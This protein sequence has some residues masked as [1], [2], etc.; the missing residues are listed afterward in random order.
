MCD[1]L[2]LGNAGTINFV[3]DKDKNQEIYNKSVDNYAHALEFVPDCHKNKKQCVIKLSI[4]PFCNKTCFERCKAKEM[5]DKAVETCSF[6]FDS[7]PD[8]YKIHEMCDKA[9]SNDPLMLKYYL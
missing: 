5:C 4:F 9:F 1:E 6:V 3:S 7:V 8:R 2:I